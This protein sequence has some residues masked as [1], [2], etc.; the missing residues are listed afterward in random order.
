M[1]KELII[2]KV[3]TGEEVN[4]IEVDN[5]NFDITEDCTFKLIKVKKTDLY[6]KNLL[7]R[8]EW[9]DHIDN[10][11]N[12]HIKVLDSMVENIRNK[13][14]SFPPLVVD[15]EGYLQDGS[16]RLTAYSEI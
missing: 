11:D 9:S 2:G 15:I 13:K 8:R 14:I 7:T 5:A 6:D 12:Y 16:H 3:Y 1:N 10:Y 4:D